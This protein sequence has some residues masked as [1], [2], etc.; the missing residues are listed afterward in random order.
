MPSVNVN[1]CEINC[2]VEGTG[3]P[4]MLIHGFASSL[5]GNWRA[6]GIVD[7]IVKAGRKVIAIDCRG[8]GRSGK[9]HDP[10]AYAGSAMADDATC[11]TCRTAP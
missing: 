3:D 7:A 1:G 8:H 2:L 5:Q 4:V 10:D 9:P 11:Q 6:P